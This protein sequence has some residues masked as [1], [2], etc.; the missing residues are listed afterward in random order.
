M[1]LIKNSPA[2]LVTIFLWMIMCY[3]SWNFGYK[4]GQTSS[5]WNW[6]YNRRVVEDSVRND[7]SERSRGLEIAERL[8]HDRFPRFCQYDNQVDRNKTDIV[9]FGPPPKCGGRTVLSLAF[10]VSQSNNL[11][12]KSALNYSLD[13]NSELFPQSMGFHAQRYMYRIIHSLNSNPG[14]IYTN[15]RF[16]PL[17]S[18]E[19]STLLQIGLIRD[20]L[21]RLTSSFYHARFGNRLEAKVVDDATWRKRLKDKHIDANETLDDCVRNKMSE[22]LGEQTKGVLVKQFCGYHRDCQTASP[23]A[24]L[25]AKNNVRNHFLIVGVLEEFDDFVQ[26]LEKLRPAIFSGSFHKLG[27][28]E[29]VKG[30]IRDSRTIGLQ[31]VTEATEAIV[32]KHLAMDYDF[33]YFIQWRFMKQREECGIN[34]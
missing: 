8:V 14:F 28:D 6:N 11:I 29:R 10:A 9:V 25:R 5:S 15:L 22:C 34:S 16:T 23:A 33:Y 30:V 24:L 13:T 3:L 20:P 27:T 19:R 4:V 18:S 31:S 26:V 1:K 2:Y 32:R 21:Q 12:I 7:Q 17:T